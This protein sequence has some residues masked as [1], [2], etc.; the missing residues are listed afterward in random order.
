MKAELIFSGS[1][2]LQGRVLNT[3]A[4]YLGRR[5]FQSDIEVGWHVTVGDNLAHLKQA[6]RQ[7]LE[8]A[9]LVLIT[10]GLGPTTDDLTKD[11]VAEVLGLQMVLDEKSLAD[12]KDLFAKRGMSMPESNTRQAIFPVGATILPNKRGT[13]PGALIE[14]ANKIIALLPGPPHE[15]SAMFED[16]LLPM[17]LE[18][19]VSGTAIRHKVF[20]LSGISESAVQDLLKDL[21]GQ[22]N[23]GITYLAKPGEIQVRVAAHAASAEQAEKMVA[24]LSE[25]VQSQLEEHIYGYDGEAV[26]QVVARLLLQK[27]MFIST[28]ESCTGGL[29]GARLTDLP[30]SSG[31]FM[32][33]VIAYSNE[34]KQSILGVAPELLEQHGA[35]SE[36]TAIAMA[37]GVRKLTGTSLG[38][39]VTGIAGPDGATTTKPRGLV[40][41]ALAAAD[42][43]TCRKFQFPG[44][45]FAVRRGTVNAALSMVNQYLK[46]R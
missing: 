24:E 6:V 11:A 1:E 38:L 44:E 42:G 20:K 37:E 26:E 27:G 29:I 18:R 32:G 23:P 41:I 13:A 19:L 21:D 17:L 5:L 39:A 34:L 35:V 30:G 10:G 40:Y 22:V 16:T 14:K 7:A 8:R 31:Y 3:H 45:R 28:A 43:T 33:G 15:M 36:E 46:V 9:D 25:K 4:Q 2:L 12:I